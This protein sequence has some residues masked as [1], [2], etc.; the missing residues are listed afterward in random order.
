MRA[1]LDGTEPTHPNGSSVGAGVGVGVAVCP[2]VGVV[3]G[4]VLPP[5]PPP[6][7]HAARAAAITTA[8]AMIK[9]R[10][11]KRILLD[12]DAGESATFVT[13]HVNSCNKRLNHCVKH[14]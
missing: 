5:P 14:S 7:P 13:T 11:L 2:G 1:T 4:G 6:P 3:T 8:V 9:E 10:L 12:A